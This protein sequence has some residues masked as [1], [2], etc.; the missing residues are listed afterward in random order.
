[1]LRRDAGRLDGLG[2]LLDS[3]AQERA[4]FSG[5]IADNLGAE[6]RQPF[7]QP[8]VSTDDIICHA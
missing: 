8:V 4:G 6:P 1:M 2:P 5:R 3:L 7:L